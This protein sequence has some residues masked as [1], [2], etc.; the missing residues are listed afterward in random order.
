MSLSYEASKSVSSIAAMASDSG[1]DLRKEA[2]R[3][4][5]EVKSPASSRYERATA[6][7]SAMCGA[8]TPFAPLHKV[9][10]SYHQLLGDAKHSLFEQHCHNTVLGH[11]H[12][13]SFY[14]VDCTLLVPLGAQGL[15]ASQ[16]LFSRERTWRSRSHQE[17]ATD[18]ARILMITTLIE[19]M[20]TVCWIPSR[21]H[22]KSDLWG[23]GL[24]SD[25]ICC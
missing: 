17:R 9:H 14:R 25:W 2:E 16:L 21:V 22:V 24:L 6:S 12:L 5:N 1:K 13:N 11:H 15:V 4:L 8:V 18:R 20:V 3:K 7:V 19:S 23:G 10:G